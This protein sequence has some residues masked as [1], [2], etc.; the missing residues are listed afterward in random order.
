MNYEQLQKAHDKLLIE[1]ADMYQARVSMGA[2]LAELQRKEYALR[3]AVC[4]MATR[5][6]AG[7][8][9]NLLS[10]DSDVAA[11]DAQVSKLV[12]FWNQAAVAAPADPMDWPLPCDVTVGAGTHKKGVRLR[13]L[14]AHMNVLHKMALG[15]APAPTDLPPL[16]RRDREHGFVA[17][18]TEEQMIEYARAALKGGA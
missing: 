1:K 9:A 7:E 3:S 10:Q 16:P 13:S 2:Q 12:D 4:S 18:Y 17:L 15:V 11:L 14:V 5:L 6:K 8:Y